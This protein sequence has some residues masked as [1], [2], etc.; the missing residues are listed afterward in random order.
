MNN[1]LRRAMREASPSIVWLARLGF[2]AKALV[3]FIVGGVAAR[4]AF[5]MGGRTTDTRGALGTILA[6]PFG[7]LLLGAV[8]V[9]LFGYAAWLLLSAVLDAEGRGSGLAGMLARIGAAVR[10]LTHAALGAQTIFIIL[11][12]RTRGGNATREWTAWLL[13]APLG[14][15]M[16]AIAGAA[17]MGYGG[18]QF[19]C[20]VAGNLAKG[21]D[22]AALGAPAARWAVRFGRFGMAARGL[23]FSV[24]GFFLIRAALMYDARQAK[25]VAQA[26]RTLTA[27]ANP[28]W[29]L[30]V[31]AIGLVSYGIYE[32][33]E[34]RYRR[35]RAA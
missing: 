4:V 14:A 29:L 20:V 1:P 8:A 27:R 31:V 7:R 25:G 12:S 17:V 13:A 21:L 34:A 16:V 9:G 30:G 18:Y 28:S 35:I 11:G 2:V 3:Y 10:G 19:Y 23:L 5:G 32:L 26:L 24:I 22:L 15:W 6:Q 33:Y